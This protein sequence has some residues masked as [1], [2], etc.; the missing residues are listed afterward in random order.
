MNICSYIHEGIVAVKRAKV[1]E[2]DGCFVRVIHPEKVAKARDG[3]I[4]EKDVE[5]LA[6]TFKTVSDPTRVRILTALKD[7][8]MCVCDMAAFLGI[9]ESAV[10]HQMRR[11][12]DLSLV[13]SRREGQVLY[14][15]LDDHHVSELIRLGLEHIRE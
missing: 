11:L 9:S 8:E 15:F 14:Y 4:G 5:R 6:R 12:K 13:R 1:I 3:A 10:S 7:E 2:E